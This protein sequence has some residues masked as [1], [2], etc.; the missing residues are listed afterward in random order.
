[1]YVSLLLLLLFFLFSE[2]VNLSTFHAILELY[3]QFL[4]SSCNFNPMRNFPIFYQ[5]FFLISD[6]LRVKQVLPNFSTLQL[7]QRNDQRCDTSSRLH[8]ASTRISSPTWMNTSKLLLY[9]LKHKNCKKRW[10][11]LSKFEQFEFPAFFVAFGL[12][13][14]SGPTLH[15]YDF[16]AMYRTEFSI[17]FLS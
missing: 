16:E 3:V 5:F 14:V 11:K 12:Y 8:G 10:Y 6:K 7:A 1:M 2:L 17:H 9:P 13:R 15:W 4:Y